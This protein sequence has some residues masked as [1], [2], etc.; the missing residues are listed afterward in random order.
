MDCRRTGVY[1]LALVALDAALAPA[2]ADTAL[3]LED[4]P[5]VLTASRLAQ[6][7]LDAPAP[8]TIIDR[9][10]IEAS[11]FTEI[12]DLL[13]LVPGFQVADWPLGSPTVANHGIGDAYD[14]RIKVMID[15]R[16]VNNPLWGDTQWDNL[17]IRVD[18][19]DHIEVVRNAN[20][21]AYGVNAFQGVINI[22]TRAPATEDGHALISRVGK[23][24]FYD[25]GVR[26][27]SPTGQAVD[28]RLSASRR[29]ATNFEAHLRRNGEYTAQEAFTRNTV[30]F[31]LSAQL[32]TQDEVR[33]QLGVSQGIDERGFP[34]LGSTAALASID[35]VQDATVRNHSVHLAWTRSFSADSELSLQLYHQGQAKRRAWTIDVPDE[36]GSR[37][38]IPTNDDLDFTRNDMELQW[39]GPLLPKVHALLGA[40]VRQ[41]RVRSR[42]YFDTRAALT[43][44]YWQTFG[45]LTWQAS[46]ALAVNLGATFEDHDYSGKLFSPRLAFNYALDARSALRLSAGRAYR[47]PSLIEAHALET[48]RENGEIVRVGY[49]AA[50]PVEPETVRFVELGYVAKPSRMLSVDLRVFREAYDRYI[51]RQSCFLPTLRGWSSTDTLPCDALGIAP[52][53]EWSEANAFGHGR[54]RNKNVKAFYFANLGGFVAR[55]GELSVD[56]RR[57]GLGRAVL[58]QAF[59]FLDASPELEERDIELSAPK[60]STALLLIAD[61]P[62][63]WQAS[64]GYYHNDP[65]YWLNDGDRVPNRDRF[66]LRLA[67]SFGPPEQAGEFAIVVQSVNGRYKEFHEG[68][69][70]HE[71]RIFASLR[72]AW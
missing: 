60:R 19:I 46:D 52:P 14:R 34:A 49:Y 40:G 71:P 62:R 12:H 20:G 44:H 48:L 57:P 59:V 10:M 26:L 50:L 51:D 6:S 38:V 17:T 56:I 11:G 61:L 7:P 21:G 43:A 32:S 24:G 53:A 55:G 1:A 35:P 72:L 27:N 9:E 36:S 64:L 58:S 42:K 5:L 3:F 18:D 29:S 67:R 37:H 54:I 45:N 69:Y 47:A 8:V 65:M 13:R 28:W 2:R 4:I 68:N 16:T 41:D 30:N 63:R 25:V 23:N 70:R 15:G 22:I 31:Q 66:D 33:A 39:S